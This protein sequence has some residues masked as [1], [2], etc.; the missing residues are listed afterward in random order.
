MVTD[1][2]ESGYVPVGALSIYFE[3]QGEGQPLLLLHGGVNTIESSFAGLRT[4]LAPGRRI[5]A[6]EQQGHG[7]TGDINRPLRYESMVEDSA[8]ALGTLRLSGVDVF[9]WSD[10]GIVGLGLAARHPRLVRRIAIC[11]AGYSADAEGPDAREHYQRLDAD[12][13]G[14]APFRE[15]YQRVAPRPKDW[16]RLVAKCKE[17][18]RSF[19]GWPEAEVRAIAAPLLVM[20]GDRDSVRLEH[21]IELFRMVP[22]GQLAVL[23][24]SDHGVPLTRGHLVAAM[25]ANFFDAPGVAGE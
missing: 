14:M 9:G 16:Q 13:M 11:G 2:R 25:L 4:T 8:S 10:G 20:V 15:A 6:I 24:G 19:E 3:S 12:G 7:R 21:A 23:P 22:Q 18:W 1:E 17:M 5:I